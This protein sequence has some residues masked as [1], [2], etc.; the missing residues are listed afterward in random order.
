MTFLDRNVSDFTEVLA[1]KNPVPGGGGASAL[2]GAVGISLSNMVGN[3]TIGKPKYADIEDE[4][5]V[6]V[7]EGEQ[8][9][10]ELLSLIDADAEAFEPLSRAYGIPK[11]DPTRDTA[12]EEALRVACAV[13]IDMMCVL[14]RAIEMHERMGQIGTAIALSDVGV[15][16]VMCKTAMRGAALNVFVNTQLM[17]DKEYATKLER[18]ASSL[19]DTYCPLADRVYETVMTKIRS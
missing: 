8:I 13:P 16:A 7:E 1:S 10:L 19:L 14:G 18:A 17:K 2:V 11:D 5:R 15:G 4:V 6:L 3:L 9:R 12:M